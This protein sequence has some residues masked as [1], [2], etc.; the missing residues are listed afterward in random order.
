MF[1]EEIF[2]LLFKK[3]NPCKSSKII[4]YGNK[5]GIV[6]SSLEP[7]RSP[8]MNVN[9]FHRLRASYKPMTEG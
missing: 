1:D 9:K 7:E 6:F 4:H 8:Y 5:V 2:I 3:E